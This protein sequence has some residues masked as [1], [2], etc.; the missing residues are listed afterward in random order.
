[1]KIG[2]KTT[3]QRVTWAQLDAIW[4]TAGSL[5]VF[6]SAWTFDHFYP[7]DGDGPCFE[8]WTALAILSRHLDRQL[9]GH[10]VLSAGYRHPAILAK[11]A[12]VMD[13]ATQGRFVLGLGAGSHEREARAYGM[14]FPAVRDR[15]LGLEKSLLVIK[16]LFAPTAGVWPA[17]NEGKDGDSGGVT[18]SAPPFVLTHARNDPL[19]L[20]SGGP[21]IWLGTQG[22]KIGLRLVAAYAA[23]WNF[24]GTGG[25]G[26]FARKRDALLAHCLELGRDATEITLSAQMPVLGRA[27]TVVKARQ[28]EGAGCDHL[29][30]SIDPRSGSEGLAEAAAV[31]EELRSTG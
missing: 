28:F 9:V 1:V 11:M 16:S 8:G 17:E 5:D 15:L 26:V 3:T 29:I 13:H 30:L 21:P 18:L 4:R 20:T 19:P 31:A 14:P 22:A 12:T 7:Y 27:A 6:D 23:G 24:D 2:F 25:P 10:L